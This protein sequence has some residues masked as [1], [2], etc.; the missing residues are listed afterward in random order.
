M[1]MANDAKLTISAS[2]DRAEQEVRKLQATGQQVTSILE[3]SFD[4]LGT[5]STIA[6]EAQRAAYVSA[7]EQIRTSGI[8]TWQEVQTAHAAM[9]AK[10]AALD[11]SL[12]PQGLKS[13][14]QHVEDIGGAV[15]RLT[16]RF[17]GLIATLGAFYVGAKLWQGFEYGIQKV[18]EFQQSVVK[19]SAMI[20]SLQGGKDIASDYQKAKEYAAGLNEV[21]MQVDSRTTLNLGNLHTITE[22]MIKQGVVLD[23]TNKDQVEGFTRLANAVAVY[24][25]NGRDERQVRQEVSALLRGQVDQSSQLSSMLQRTVDG[26]LKKQVDQ[27]RQSGTLVE[28]LGKR[29]GGFGPA[30]DDLATSWGAV[31]SSFETS[32][33]LVAQAGFTGIVKEISEWLGKIN[34]YLKE[35]REEIGG[36]IKQGWEEAKAL[37]SGAATIAKA[38]YNNFEPF[39]AFFVA[40]AMLSGAARL[41]SIFKDIREVVIAIRGIGLITAGAGVAGGAAGAAGAGAVGGGILATI[42]GG[43]A[44]SLAAIGAGVGVGYALQPAVRWAD[45]KLYQNL[46]VNLTGEAMS[47]E[48]Q[49]RGSEA[50]ARWKFF[51][52]ENARSP[53]N[54][55]SSTASIP[56]LNLGDTPEQIAEKIKFGEK[57]LAAFKANQEGMSQAAKEQA[58][59]RLAV[60]KNNLETGLISTREYYEAEKAAAL[61]AAQ[62]K[63]QNAAEYLQK[64]KTL[65]SYVAGKKGVD[66]PEYQEELAK[67]N[68]G[69]SE[70]KSAQ[71]EYAKVYLDSEEKMRQAL[72]AREDEYA[73][74]TEQSLQDSGEYAA[75]ESLRQDMYRKS[76]AY[77]QLEADALDG[78]AKAWQA[79]MSLEQKEASDSLAAQQKKIS[80]A[81]QYQSEID[82]MRDEVDRLNGKDQEVIRTEEKLRDGVLKLANMQD[83][84]RIAWAKADKD[85]ISGLS[86]K[87]QLQDLLN[88]RVQQE[89]DLQR[90]KGELNGTIV[91]YNGKTPIYA[92]QYAKEQA[93]SGYVPNS[94]LVVTGSGSSSSAGL[95]S[96]FVPLNSPINGWDGPSFDVGTPF[97][98]RT[99][100]AKIHY[101]ER[102]LT[103]KENASGNFGST[104]FTFGD[105]HLNLPNVTNQSTGADLAREALPELMR[106]MQRSRK[107][108]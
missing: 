69:V 83:D 13:V 75:A 57:E 95:N 98:P 58:S 36:K 27:W 59:I 46:G 107:A 26:P 42:G 85:A 101:G 32:L 23:Y 47:D 2:V 66:S 63:F 41:L 70:M 21:L 61:D 8:A 105:V 40:G 45:R 55:A 7:Y 3:Q 86:Q 72:R 17:L 20:T 79:M 33:S 34:N 54:R 73:K 10:I 28:E 108:A 65:L 60:L 43:L 90:R 56:K 37:M 22:E 76:K 74:L 24:S 71:L 92:D 29:L 48:T 19:T 97:V 52:S 64:E 53:Q 94:Q 50:D 67:H 31:K 9:T 89:I 102:I 68:K 91:G 11:A 12:K 25:N 62:Q 88:Q 49:Q 87:I 81:R 80:V 96:P 77:L 14:S 82:K 4:R 30:A 84:L 5:Q 39:A 38:I 51:Q 16:P 44:G 6:V 35:H 18:D 106:L 15:D 104:S 93:A 1:Q 78:N 100:I 103:A 99:M